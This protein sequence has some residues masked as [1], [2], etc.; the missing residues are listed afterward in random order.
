MRQTRLLTRREWTPA[1]AWDICPCAENFP[2]CAENIFPCA[3]NF[4]THA[5]DIFPRVTILPTLTYLCSPDLAWLRSIVE[6]RF[7]GA[8]ESFFRAPE[9]NFRA[10][11]SIFRVHEGYPGVSDACLRGGE[12]HPCA[13]G[14]CSC[15]GETLWHVGRPWICIPVPRP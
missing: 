1:W 8:P 11:G 13:Y 4:P 10:Y 14:A 2:T 3:G 5:G 6:K 12:V 15:A 7:P 9:R